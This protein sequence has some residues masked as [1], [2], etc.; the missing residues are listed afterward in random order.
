MTET[1]LR[2]RLRDA[3]PAAMR[4][5]DRAAV[6]ALRG[7]LAAIE[8]A[9]AIAIGDGAHRSLAIE[10]TPIGVG[11]AE[12]PRRVLTDE[13]VAEIVRMEIAERESTATYYE[14]A[15]HS[16]RA[17]QLRAEARALTAG[18]LFPSD[19]PED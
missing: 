3:L 12:A 14:Q 13:E 10:Q 1:P 18:T 2:Q 7:A 19:E 4:T 6:V 9:E 17:E 8:N 11:A 16:D 15:G 5:R